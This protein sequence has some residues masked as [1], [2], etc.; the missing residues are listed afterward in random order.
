M[1]YED[2]SN[3]DNS[4]LSYMHS[5][6]SSTDGLEEVPISF[7]DPDYKGLELDVFCEKHGKAAHSLLHLKQHTMGE[8]HKCGFVHWVDHEWSPTM[9]NALL[10][11]W[12]MVQESKIARVNDN[13]GS[14]FTIHNLKEE[15]NN[16]DANYD[17]LVQDVH[18][19]MDMQ[20]DRNLKLKNMKEKELLSEARM[21][22]ELNIAEFTKF[23]EKLSQEKVELK[24]QVA[25]LLKGK[26]KHN[27]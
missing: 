3:D 5:S 13:L 21:N 4:S 18:Q 2:E 12:A 9:E 10:K 26:E 17:R 16:L 24:F 1:V 11:L 22:L 14:A 15:K 20:E 19:L 25:D 8:D 7:E 27:E 6:S 23:E